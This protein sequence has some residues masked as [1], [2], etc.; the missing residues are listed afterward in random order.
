MLNR[1][2]FPIIITFSIVRKPSAFSGKIL[3]APTVRRTGRD[4]IQPADK[5][6]FPFL[7]GITLAVEATF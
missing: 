4:P 6:N 1:T 5:K 2:K 7:S 3:S